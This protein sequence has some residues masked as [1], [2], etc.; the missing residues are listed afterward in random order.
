[1]AVRLNPESPTHTHTLVDTSNADL[2]KR[3]NMKAVDARDMVFR[4]I[5]GNEKKR[6]KCLFL[7][8][9]RFSLGPRFLFNPLH[10]FHLRF[11]LG[12]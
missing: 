1:M 5:R 8:N 3:T 6:Q 11:F 9:A 7:K 2:K 10:G 4:D 12:S